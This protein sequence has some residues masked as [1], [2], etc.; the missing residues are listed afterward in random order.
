MAE[1][2]EL[3]L[4][5]RLEMGMYRWRHVDP[6]VWTRLAVPLA[7]A[8]VGLVT[9]AGLYR[10]AIDKPFERVRGGDYSFRII[11]DDVAVSTLAVGQTS[12]AFDREPVYA[13]RNAGLPI[14]RLRTLVHRG[15][16]GA[17]ALRHLSFNGSITAPGRL[18]RESAPEATAVFRRDGVD[19][20]LLV[21]V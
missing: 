16:V 11:P 9:T 10:P 21:P 14:E 3:P 5:Y 2:S 12:A 17:S 15:E 7:S 19:A 4:R 13:D 20:A 6:L 1:F 18:V 8:R